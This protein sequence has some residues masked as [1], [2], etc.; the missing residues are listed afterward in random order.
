MQGSFNT[1]K[2]KLEDYMQEVKKIFDLY[3]QIL[4]CLK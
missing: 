1:A 3:D 2:R 4:N